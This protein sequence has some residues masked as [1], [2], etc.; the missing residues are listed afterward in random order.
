MLVWVV[1][2]GDVRPWRG[3]GPVDEGH[4]PSRMSSGYGSGPPMRILRGRHGHSASCMASP[5]TTALLVP[6]WRSWHN[7]EGGEGEPATNC[8]VTSC[9]HASRLGASDQASRQPLHPG[10]EVLA[11]NSPRCLT[12]LKRELGRMR[13]TRSCG[14]GRLPLQTRMIGAEP[15]AEHARIGDAPVNSGSRNTSVR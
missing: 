1:S 14:L 8:E 15:E 11:G 12:K 10:T 6:R 13:P 7:R 3:L 4:K 2:R 9:R 5:G